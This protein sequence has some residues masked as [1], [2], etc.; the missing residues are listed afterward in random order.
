M[1]N[2]YFQLHW[3]QPIRYLAVVPAARDRNPRR[4]R[5][6]MRQVSD[7]QLLMQTCHYCRF[8]ILVPCAIVFV[9][10]SAMVTSCWRGVRSMHG[11]VGNFGDVLFCNASLNRSVIIV[12]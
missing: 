5:E 8:G 4:T 11:F 9:S 2:G 3:N 6:G 10:P 12:S 7:A 1:E